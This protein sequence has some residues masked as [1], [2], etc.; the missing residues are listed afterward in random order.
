[1]PD[2]VPMKVRIRKFDVWIM[3]NT[4]LALILA[5][6]FGLVTQEEANRAFQWVVDRLEF[7]VVVD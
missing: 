6:Q 4:G 5:Y 2:V 7:A 3:K 1:M